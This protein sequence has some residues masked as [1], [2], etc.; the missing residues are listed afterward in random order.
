MGGIVNIPFAQRNAN[1][2]RMD[3][4]FWIE[5]V[6]RHWDKVYFQLQYGQRVILD[7]DNVHWPH[8]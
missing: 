3:A 5:T 8:V 4:I 1:A 2:V 6:N 7:F